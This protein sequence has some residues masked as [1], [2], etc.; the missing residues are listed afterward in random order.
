[1]YPSYIPPLV[2]SN[3]KGKEVTKVIYQKQSKGRENHKPHKPGHKSFTCSSWSHCLS[4]EIGHQYVTQR[5]TVFLQTHH[6]SHSAAKNVS[7]STSSKPTSILSYHLHLGLLS[8]HFSLHF[9][10]TILH[11]YMPSLLISQIF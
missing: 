3:C 6:W 10:L 9:P 7:C 5:F 4:Q 11:Y 1:M 8:D 2:S